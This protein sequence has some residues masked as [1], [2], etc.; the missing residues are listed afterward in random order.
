MN[1]L[2]F[3]W[4]SPI[5]SH[6]IREL[7]RHH[8][9]VRY[10]ERGNGLS[11]WSVKDLS[12]PAWMEDL[13]T[14]VEAAGVERFALLGISQG[15]AVACSYAARHPERVSHLVLYGAFARGWMHRGSAEEIERRHAL[16]TLVRLG[17]G[18]NNPAFRQLWTNLFMP[19]ATSEQM[20]WFN[21]LQS[22]SASPD[23]AAELMREAGHIN[24]VDLLP[25]IRV[26]TLVLHCEDELAVPF[27]EG[28]LLAASIPGA[29]LVPL[30]GRN[31]LVLPTEPAW[32]LFL[33]EL[34]DFLGWKTEAGAGQSG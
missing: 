10:D 25:Q 16:L 22:V 27:D 13:E 23:N 28:R 21:E 2:E 8:R 3:E 26:P 6:W 17:W 34:G 11:D 15:G 24:V 32:P 33:R 20:D 30:P 18:T 14:V 7:I 19:G 29:R 9:F 1:H 4:Q 31:H 12:F 5:W